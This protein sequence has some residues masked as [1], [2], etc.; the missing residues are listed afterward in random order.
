MSW[1]YVPSVLY[2]AFALFAWIDFMHAAQD[3]LGNLGLLLATLP[4]TA[5]GV[6][7][8]SALGKTGFV[9]IPSGVDYYIAHAIYFWP[10]A[11]L[12]AGGLLG[13]CSWIS[14]LFAP[15]VK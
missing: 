8:T 11:L 9:L 2:L 10:A 4:V 1:K 12:I 6:I 3:G 14:R 7:L 5:V 15:K 13:F